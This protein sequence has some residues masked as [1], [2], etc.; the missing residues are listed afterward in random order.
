M[1]CA[2]WKNEMGHPLLKENIPDYWLIVKYFSPSRNASASPT[3]KCDPVTSTVPTDPAFFIANVIPSLTEPVKR[4]GTSTSLNCRFNTVASCA[5]SVAGC[6]K[7][8]HDETSRSV[9]TMG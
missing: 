1:K 4:T 5:R 2:G 7:M 6:T 9:A 8:A 3:T